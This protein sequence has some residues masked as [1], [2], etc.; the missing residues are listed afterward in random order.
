MRNAVSCAVVFLLAAC[1]DAYSSLVA[2]T[3]VALEAEVVHRWNPF[4]AAANAVKAAFTPVDKMRGD[5]C[6]DRKNMLGHEECMEWMVK[7]CTAKGAEDQKRCDKLNAYVKKHCLEGNTVACK[8]AQDLGISMD[9][10]VL[11]VAPAPSPAAAP[12]PES[13]PAPAPA[14]KE[15]K[16]APAP[17]PAK[18]EAAPAP[19]VAEAEVAGEPA[20]LQ[21]QG[22]E[23]KKVR[24]VDGETYNSDWGDEY[25]HP[26]TTTKKALKKSGAVSTHRPSLAMLIIGMSSLAWA[27]C[28]IA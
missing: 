27:A 17:A 8:Y 11:S 3:H 15:E 19:A 5:M 25:E 16:E 1:A 6:W 26:T 28:H 20:K 12:S 18:E 23:G 13:E 4:A 2:R 14:P 10:P 9:P 7:K 24:H 21:S 22:F